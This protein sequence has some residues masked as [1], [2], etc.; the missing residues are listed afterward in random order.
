[1]VSPDLHVVTVVDEDP[2]PA[3]A[4]NDCVVAEGQAG[5]VPCPFTVSLSGPSGKSIGFS[6]ATA[7]GTARAIADYEPASGT[8]TMPPG[9]TTLPLPVN[10]IGDPM[11]E[12]DETYFVNLS[13]VTN[14]TVAD[15]Q[16]LGRIL[17][18][19]LPPS[20][21]ISD[22]TVTD[23][24]L[25]GH[26][27][28]KASLSVPSGFTVTVDYVTRD[29]TARAG[30][31]YLAAGPGRLTFP[32]ETPAQV[33]TV[34]VVP[35]AHD[36]AGEHF[37]VDFSDPVN[38]TLPD[39]QARAT[40]SDRP[41][42]PAC[43]VRLDP[44]PDGTPL[45]PDLLV[46]EVR[47]LAH[48]E[49]YNSGS[50]PVALGSAAHHLASPTQNVALA[51]LAPTV[52]VPPRSYVSLPWPPGFTDV[53]TLQGEMTIF[54]DGSL[55]GAAMLDFTCWGP[56]SDPGRKELAESVAK[57]SGPCFSERLGLGG[58]S[59]H[60]LRATEGTTAESY[61][62]ATGSPMSCVGLFMVSTTTDKADGLCDA[63][64]S[65]REAIQDSNASPG[66]DT[67]LLPP[68]M[69]V[70]TLLGPGEDES[71][72][73]DL[74]VM[75]ELDLVGKGPATT[76]IDG[77]EGDRVL[78]VLP[79]ASASLWGLTLRGGR[80]EAAPGG[81]ILDQG[82][83][84]AV[85]TLVSL[86]QAADGG[87]IAVQG[88]GAS[89]G[90]VRSTLADNVA[91]GNGGAV[92]ADCTSCA[93]TLVDSTLSGNRA[94]GD[95][96]GLF[97]GP[98]AR[99][100]LASVTVTGNEADSDA[101]GGGQGG[102]LSGAPG[103]T[104]TLRNSVVAR[105]LDP[106]GGA[107]DCDAAC[108]CLASEGY[109]LIGEDLGCSFPAIPGDQVGTKEAIDPRLGLLANNGGPTPTHA[110]LAESPALDAA[111]PALPGSG[112]LACEAVDQ[113]SFRR[114]W[115]GNGDQASLCDAGSFELCP[116]SFSDVTGTPYAPFVVEIA[117]RGITSGCGAGLFCP[118]RPVTRAEMAVFLVA[119]LGEHGSGALHD[120]YFDDVANDGF[121][122][123]INRLFEL[124]LTGGC[125]TRRYCPTQDVSRKQM[126][127]FLVSG[128]EE[129]PSTA[130]Y[131]AYFT[132]L[133]DDGFAPYV[134]RIYEL[135]ITGGCGPGRFCPDDPV[136]RGPMAVFLVTSFFRY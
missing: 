118:D 18:D 119:S 101:A 98:G 47:P 25:G 45:A 132:D 28:I 109:N 2:P 121:A 71:A 136:R 120:E 43:A 54:A 13:A 100:Q 77:N 62:V 6:F 53:S 123:Y 39:P 104:L 90:L 67:V 65:L 87:G 29:G 17:D 15:G 38:A 94:Q 37:F 61:A 16:G 22:V 124:G 92:T 23:R 4:I 112:G 30:Q 10:V 51:A 3:L 88:D 56:P 97:K 59:L 72:T 5:M 36:E 89:L 105:N 66:P 33:V 107:P 113:R 130:P 31:D 81:G 84:R 7:D 108:A 133:A 21:S 70:L 44:L 95:G 35:D 131:D 32:P 20:L 85:D 93:L 27:R 63:D 134:N 128:M 126:A 55:S 79:G 50:A 57:W 46:S 91:S 103:G 86:N 116:A 111:N 34:P 24:R 80:S 99:V 115:D 106:T 125:G 69:Y 52:V 76:V 135:G 83:L 64:C 26:A 68:G 75:D 122:P 19:D 1:V 129:K 96:G 40:L 12:P 114:P 14:A 49:V 8:R 48:V 102:G 60:R 73:G 74:D 117:C 41:R 127:V 110:L 78:H 58:E 82:A 42:P 9:T 11:D